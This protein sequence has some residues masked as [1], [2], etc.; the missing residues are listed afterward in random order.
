MPIS[1]AVLYTADP[2]DSA[3]VEIRV[4]RPA[5]YA[6]VEIL[7]G[8]RAGDIDL[9][10]VEQA[11]L[12]II[13]RDFP[14]FP[15]SPQVVQSARRLHKPVIYETDDWLFDV[16]DGN[17]QQPAYQNY[18]N[19][20]LWTVLQADRVVTC[21]PLLA[22]KLALFNPAVGIFENYLVDKFWPLRAPAPSADGLLTIGFMGSQTH[23]EDVRELAPV[24]K[25]L[26]DKYADRLSLV[27]WGCRPP[28]E[29][30]ERPDVIWHGEP[31]QSYAEFAHY[32]SQQAS[33]IFI[34][35]LSVH[36]FNRAKSPLKY[37]EYTALGVPGVYSRIDP[38]EQVIT[39][40]ENGLLAGS[41]Q[42]WQEKIEV[43][44][45]SPERRYRLAVEAQARLTHDWLLSDHYTRWLDAL[46]GPLPAPDGHSA[47]A[48]AIL[49]RITQKTQEQIWKM[50]ADLG[51]LAQEA[52][53]LRGREVDLR[54]EQAGL[55]SHLD[56]VLNS[57]TWKLAQKIQKLINLVRPRR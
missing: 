23:Q 39:D 9:G 36:E 17:I 21:G 50:E 19:G 5:E 52:A 47:P 37:F 43:L 28:E 57:S 48:Q 12:V 20:M 55:R 45:L 49:G 4:R 6:G 7:Q 54:N 11:D 40:G 16:P 3:L 8:N 24:L 30:R 35:P 29:L 25:T 41:L 26:L 46:T 27:F 38:Y 44:I 53:G 15:A 31:F 10:L 18:L 34:A 33:D 13:Q 42:E 14:R 56:A 1:R 22:D 32:F 2:W 51:A